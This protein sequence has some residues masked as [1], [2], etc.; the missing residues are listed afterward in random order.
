[1]ISSISSLEII[2]FVIREATSKG[3]EANIRGRTHPKMFL[4]IAPSVADPA[5]VN[6]N[7]IKTL[8]PYGFSTFFIKVNDIFSNGHNSL[9]KYSL[10]SRILYNWA[11]GNFILPGELFAKALRNFET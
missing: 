9:P 5:A 1:M 7:G 11:F 8:L 2:N 6:S 10:D 4:W 3:H